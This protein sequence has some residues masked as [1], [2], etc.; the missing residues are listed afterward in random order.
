MNDDKESSCNNPVEAV[1]SWISVED[2][3]PELCGSKDYNMHVVCLLTTGER[4]ICYML[5]DG[6]W[7]S[8]E[9]NRSD[10]DVTHWM[11]TSEAQ[12]SN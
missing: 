10:G 9:V 7:E 6:V 3:L 4:Q 1:V 5:E 8:Y 12:Q 11:P 2:K